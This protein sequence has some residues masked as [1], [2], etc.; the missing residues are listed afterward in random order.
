MASSLTQTLPEFK[1]VAPF[2]Y[3]SPTGR[4]TRGNPDL[5]KSDVTN[6]DLKYE[7]FPS[8]GEL[9]SATGFYK[10]IKNPINLAQTRGSAGIFEYANT[11]NEANV[12]GLEV[13]G[14]FDLISNEE[15][16]SLLNFN[17][18]ITKMWFNQDLLENYQFKNQTE[19]DLQGAS[20]LIINSSLS[21]NS[22]TD[23]EFNATL[24]GNY[25]SDKIF[26]LGSP[27]DFANS[28]VLYNDAIIEKGFVTLDLVLSKE[29]TDDLQLKF[30]GR[31]I[32]NPE[33]RQTQLIRN[34]NTGVETDETVLSYKKGS[35]LSLSLKYTF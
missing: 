29:L 27:E 6:I 15:E 14:R 28:A 13:E 17:A 32:L 35:L 10:N 18:N 31:N 2:E 25:S 30:V 1:E 9:V 24:T 16:E 34:I 33:I 8:N 23:K 21:Y 7:F 11:G 5:E 12:Y 20:D 22:Q 26:A 3:V 19:T 4:V